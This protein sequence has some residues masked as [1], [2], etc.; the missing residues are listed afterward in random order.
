MGWTLA[1]TGS[2]VVSSVNVVP[3]GKGIRTCPGEGALGRGPN[4][5]LGHQGRLSR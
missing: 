2:V 4:P 1:G 5:A 3:S